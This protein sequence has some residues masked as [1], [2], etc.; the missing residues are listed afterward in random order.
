MLY[1]ELLFSSPTFYDYVCWIDH[2][3]LK[4]ATRPI[5]MRYGSGLIPSVFG[6]ILGNEGLKEIVQ[7]CATQALQHIE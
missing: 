5:L 4:L 6:S 2:A 7:L 3:L 1:G